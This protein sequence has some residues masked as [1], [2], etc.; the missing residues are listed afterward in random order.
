MIRNA[1]LL[2]LAMALAGQA[3]WLEG[4]RWYQH[5]KFT[6]VVFDLSEETDYR[7]SKQLDRG[8]VDVL[9]QGEIRRRMPEQVDIGIGGVSRAEE[10][11]KTSTSLTYRLHAEGIGRVR[12]MFLDEMPYKIVVDFY[13]EGTGQDA[14]V[15]QVKPVVAPARQQEKPSVVSR[16]KS[17]PAVAKP[18]AETGPDRYSDL[19]ADAKRRVYIAELLMQLKDT[20]GAAEHLVALG[21]QTSE[22]PLVRY[23]LALVH[24]YR[25][26][27][28]RAAG[29]IE[30]LQALPEWSER[31][32][33]LASRLGPPDEQ[34]QLAG[35]DISDEEIDFFLSVMRRGSVL[36]PDDVY[37]VP[38]NR[39]S[40]LTGLLPG[41]LIG[42]VLGVILLFFREWQ[43]RQAR[44]KQRFKEI[45]EEENAAKDEGE[46]PLEAALK[47]D[48]ADVSRRVREEL[49]DYMHRGATQDPDITAVPLAS[50]APEAPRT[51]EPE[52]E[53]VTDSDA[54]EDRVYRLADEKKSIV[55]IAEG[56]NL[57]VDEVRLILELRESA[58]QVANE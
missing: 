27:D 23:L 2:V 53:P 6:R 17:V 51:P 45:M 58:G 8:Y 31:A 4:L 28:Y 32:M 16:P 18:A 14:E 57:G 25:G 52:T 43:H 11:R 48:Y 44:F 15:E 7:L 49:E 13:P 12:T 5:D 34:G 1:F 3:A 47:D 21:D 40:G 26:D 30:A 56:L 35:G 39:S 38:V 29:E 50:P 54:L 9:F 10:L 55:E 46:T 37:E 36:D 22:H 24:L 41:I 20:S 19:P 33:A 42:L